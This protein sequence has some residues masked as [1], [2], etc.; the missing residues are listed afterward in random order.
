ML[1]YNSNGTR[2][3]GLANCVQATSVFQNG[4]QQKWNIKLKENIKIALLEL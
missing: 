4:C 2:S 1:K 3:Q